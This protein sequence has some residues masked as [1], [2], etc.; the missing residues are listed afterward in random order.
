MGA[1]AARDAAARIG[2]DT[3]DVDC[4]LVASLSKRD[5]QQKLAHAVADRLD[6][7][8]R[9]ALDVN[10]ASGGFCSALELGRCLVS[11]GTYDRVLVV[12]TERTHDSGLVEAGDPTGPHRAAGAGAVLL[13]A[14]DEPGIST[15]AWG[16]GA[17]PAQVARTAV[18]R[19][20]L[21]MQG[22]RAFVSHRHPDERIRQDA[23]IV[24][25]LARD[26]IVAHDACL[27]GSPSAASIPAAIATLLAEFPA[28]S[29]EPALLVG[30][31]AELSLAA[32]V[33]RLP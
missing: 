32:Q 11:A 4:V 24:L 31:G 29:G 6:G 18:Q 22:V 14:G 19:A 9:A 20:G 30:F 2:V 15:P 26:V 25:S 13:E 5:E 8:P 16:S 33:V 10:A 7:T 3:D 23:A 12:G 21:R 17:A 28:L 27:S 1:R